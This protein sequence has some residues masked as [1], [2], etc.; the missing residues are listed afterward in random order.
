MYDIVYATLHIDA[1][2]SII[3]L[4]LCPHFLLLSPI[5]RMFFLWIFFVDVIVVDKIWQCWYICS[6]EGVAVVDSDWYRFV[7]CLYVFLF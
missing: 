3:P 5:V 7:M 1:I 4:Y 6:R 2:N